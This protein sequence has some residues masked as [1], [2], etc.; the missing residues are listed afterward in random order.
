M[1]EDEIKDDGLIDV[2]FLILVSYET[3]LACMPFLLSF[4]SLASVFLLFC[5]AILASI[6]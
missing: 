2:C 3:K 4:I 6:V 1:T 5:A